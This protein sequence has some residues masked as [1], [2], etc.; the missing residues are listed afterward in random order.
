[1]NKTLIRLTLSTLPK[2]SCHS[3]HKTYHG[4]MASP[5]CEKHL[6]NYALLHTTTH[7]FNFC[8]STGS[9]RRIYSELI[10]VLPGTCF[11]HPIVATSSLSTRSDSVLMNLYSSSL[12]IGSGIANTRSGSIRNNS[13]SI[14]LSETTN[15]Q[16]ISL[17]TWKKS[18]I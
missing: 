17:H 7:H 6:G 1:M 4:G 9:L 11:A 14:L 16:V 2:P 12:S 18:V 3:L 15:S 10:S 13:L 8:V 5:Q